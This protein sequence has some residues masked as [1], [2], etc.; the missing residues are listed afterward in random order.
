[1]HATGARI[2]QLWYGV[3]IGAFQ[4]GQLTIVENQS[5]QVVHGS[6]LF[7]NPHVR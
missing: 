4:L 6:K 3:N 5:R 2:Y 1:M 7:Q